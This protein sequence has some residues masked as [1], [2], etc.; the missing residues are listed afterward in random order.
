MIQ[1][2]RTGGDAFAPSGFALRSDGTVWAWGADTR[3]VLGSHP[4]GGVAAT[5]IR[6]PGLTDV[7]S[8]TT[9]FHTGYAL[10]SDGTV[11]SWGSNEFGRLG[12][13][14]TGYTGTPARIPGLTGITQLGANATSTYAL[15]SDGTVWA[16]GSNARGQLGANSTAALSRTP[17]QVSGL[18]GVTSLHAGDSRL[19][20]E[21]TAHAVLTDGSLWSWGMNQ[22]G[23]LGTGSTPGP[24]RVPVRVSG[25]TGVTQLI[26]G[27][28]SYA[29]RSDGTV[30]GG[31]RTAS[32]RSRTG[33]RCCGHQ[34]GC[35]SPPRSSTSAS[36]TPGT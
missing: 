2:A 18:A 28:T 17:V 8:I 30:W 21:G 15:R 35:G 23:Q 16:W 9:A 24:A 14:S 36:A 19:T 3:D 11:W 25:L 13:N 4:P 26:A 34:S 29:L 1:V 32:A 33:L 20:G 31:V 10:R 27:G 5:P 22:N 12:T 6:V 7:R